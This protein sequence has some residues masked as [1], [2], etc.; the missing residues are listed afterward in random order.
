[1]EIKEG[2]RKEYQIR[3]PVKGRKSFVVT[4]P[5]EVVDREAR[6]RQLTILELI[7]K[8]QVVAT[9]DNFEGVH[10]T[11]EEIADESEKQ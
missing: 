7:E 5:Y 10:Y 11:F 4:L 1:M 8:F 6:K 3:M 9:Y 2:Y